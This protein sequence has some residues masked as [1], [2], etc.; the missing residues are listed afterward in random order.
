[1]T[2]KMTPQRVNEILIDQHMGC[3]QCVMAHAAQ[4]LGLMDEKLALRAS[5]G[6]QGGCFGGDVCGA[7]A[8]AVMALGLAFPYDTPNDNDQKALLVS[9][10]TEFRKRFTEKH[11]SLICRELLGGSFADPAILPT[12]RVK[13][14]QFCLDACNIVDDIIEEAKQ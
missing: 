7:V 5:G 4:D 3:S 9:K 11:G 14:P 8:G 12:M 10:V 13:C 1:M 6:L 2:A